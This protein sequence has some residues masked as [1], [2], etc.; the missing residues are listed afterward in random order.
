MDTDGELTEWYHQPTDPDPKQDLGYELDSW[1]TAET[2]C[3]GEKYVV[4]VSSKERA[5]GE[6]EY[7]VAHPNAVCDP[8]KRR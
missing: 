4:F 2:W 5:D 8:V 3:R 6:D 1:E 7:I